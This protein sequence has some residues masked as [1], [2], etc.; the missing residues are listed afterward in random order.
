MQA[1]ISWQ[2]AIEE[3][4]NLKRQADYDNDCARKDEYDLLILRLTEDL[5][6]QIEHFQNPCAGTAIEAS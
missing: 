6:C 5:K 2:K 3:F 1:V 4:Q